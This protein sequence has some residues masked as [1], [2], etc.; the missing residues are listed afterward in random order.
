MAQMDARIILAGQPV[1]ALGALNAGT[2][3]AANANQVGR[4]NA[5]SD[6]F[7]TQG[8]G[9]LSGDAGALNALAG[10]DPMAALDVRSTQQQMSERQE[11]LAMARAAAAQQAATH[12]AN[13][14]AAEREAEAAQI[15][16]GLLYLSP[17]YSRGDRAAFE[18]G[19]QELDPNGEL[20]ITWDN[21][22]S[23]AAMADGVLEVLESFDARNAGVAGGADARVQ[24]SEILEDGTVV[25]VMSNGG[26]LVR[27]PQGEVLEGE[28]AQAAITQAR[29]QA[30][31]NQR[32]IYAARGEGRLG[33]EAEFGG[34]AAQATEL[35][36]A[37]GEMAVQSAQD[38]SIIW[39]S[40]GNI[41]TA[42]DALDNGADSGMIYNMMP[43]FD[44][45]GATLQNA[46]DR[47]GL[48]VIGMVTFGALSEGELRLAMST[49]VP[50]NLGPDA[51]RAWLVRRRDAQ[52]QAARAL[53]DAALYLSTP[54]NT[55]NGW[56][57]RNRAM[58]G[59]PA[60]PEAPPAAA[61]TAEPQ[62]LRYNL[63]TGEF[64]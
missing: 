16:Q 63:E 38:A 46:M 53:E 40:I 26:V 41:D 61:P 23:Q 11:R 52:V 12:A 30:V 10:L 22:E 55:I 4:D 8:A 2:T 9:I 47:M 19:V 59:A 57:A 34:A 42:I 6:L 25:A 48:D 14:T 49:A 20:G 45:A 39:G 5:M 36:Q 44:E 13:M 64:E 18:A 37:A 31:E 51:L 56:I 32:N 1:N 58:R 21:F 54:G 33:A 43:R 29:A 7:R 60:A 24:S 35:G 50:R 62:V 27:G 17:L 3:A 15:R 28:A